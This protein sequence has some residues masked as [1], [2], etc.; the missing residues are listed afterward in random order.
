MP[1]GS[2]S[3]ATRHRRLRASLLSLAEAVG[4]VLPS[5]VQTDE[6]LLDSLVAALPP[7]LRDSE[8][9]STCWPWLENGSDDWML[10]WFDMLKW[11]VDP[12]RAY[13]LHSLVANVWG[14]TRGDESQL[15]NLYELLLAAKNDWARRSSGTFYTPPPMARYL[16]ARSDEKLRK[17]LQLAGGL[18]DPAAR[19]LEPACGSGEFIAAVVE[20][21]TGRGVGFEAGSS[22]PDQELADRQGSASLD[23]LA[24]LTAIDTSPAA[25]FVTRLRIALLLRQRGLELTS[26]IPQPRLI[27]GN[28]LAGPELVPALSEPANVVLGNPPFSYLSQNDLPWIQQLIRGENG[29]AGYFAIGNDR[30]NEKKTWLHDD[31]VKFLRLAQWCIERNGHGVVSLVTNHGW[32]DNATFRIARQ[33][34]LQTFD[35]IEIVDLHGNAKRFEAGPAGER[36]EN[37]FGIAQGI[38]LATLTRSPRA[39]EARVTRSDLWGS[40]VNKLNRLMRASAGEA[41]THLSIKPASPWFA[42][43]CEQRVAPLEYLRA[44]LLTEL[45]PVHS[46]VPVT[47]RDHF[48]VAR[49]AAELLD[50]IERF[51]D[52]RIPDEQIRAEYFQ[53]TRSQR[54]KPG[55]TRSWKLSEARRIVRESGN[56]QSFIRRCL[57][58]PFVWR[59]VFWHPAMIDWPRPEVTSHLQPGNRAILARRQSLAGRECNFFWVTDSLPLDGVIRSDNRGSESFF[60][61]WL[62]TADEKQ[63]ANFANVAAGWSTPEDLFA[64]CYGLFHSREYRTRYA[65]GLAQE[66]PRILLP[67]DG[68]LFQQIV[69]LGNALM[70]LHLTDPHDE[71]SLAADLTAQ[72]SGRE[73]EIECFYVGTYNVCRKWLQMEKQ[74]RESPVFARLRQLIAATIDLQDQID[75]SIRQVGGFPAAFRD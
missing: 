74:S 59:Y 66:F 46:T 25:I 10:P 70:V 21:L 50:R 17:E 26:D 65:S 19:I 64:W 27:V 18:G 63:Q 34:L 44:P 11:L 43:E 23:F 40:R 73:A 29:R 12:E 36:D 60:P 56:P 45:M 1:R 28:A 68:E 53:R 15:W 62:Y 8:A 5:C 39:A 13:S 3:L 16:V 2:V 22:W 51:C 32:L 41:L 14:E 24:R 6:V 52:L 69:Q 57:Y 58:R 35:Q 30:L 37:V 9:L 42:F 38:A 31:Y 4:S 48:V 49:T 75:A 54:Y 20:L 47:A 61:L 55:D 72:V 67:R 7:V 71:E 33:Q